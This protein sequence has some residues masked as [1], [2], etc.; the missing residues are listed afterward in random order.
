MSFWAIAKNLRYITNKTHKILHFTAFHSEWPPCVIL[1]DSEESRKTWCNWILR[2]Y[3]PLND[4]K[5]LTQF[6]H[7]QPSFHKSAI[8]EDTSKKM[9]SFGIQTINWDIFSFFS[10]WYSFLDYFL[11]RDNWFVNCRSFF[12]SDIPYFHEVSFHPDWTDGRDGDS[13]FFEFLI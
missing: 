2:R 12:E 1:S 8:W 6:L 4:R 3:A 11:W 10:I 5:T 13:A 9:H 7:L